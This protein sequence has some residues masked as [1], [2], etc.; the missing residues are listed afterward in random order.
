[1]LLHIVCASVCVKEKTT[2]P[3]IISAYS[4]TAYIEEYALKDEIFL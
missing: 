4:S 1:M 3:L 2:R